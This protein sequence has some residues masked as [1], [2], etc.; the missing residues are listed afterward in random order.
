MHLA[1][2]PRRCSRIPSTFLRS[3]IAT[4]LRSCSF[5]LS[6]ANDCQVRGLVYR[7]YGF[8][9]LQRMAVRFSLRSLEFFLFCNE[10]ELQVQ[11]MQ[12]MLIILERVRF[13]KA[14]SN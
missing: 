4:M 10:T 14:L 13:C 3:L 12:N 11:R 2:I 6:S 8:V 7:S 9:S 1:S 5:L